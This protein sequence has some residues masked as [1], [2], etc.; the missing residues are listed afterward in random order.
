LGQQKAL[1]AHTITEKSLQ[2]SEIAVTLHRQ[3]EQNPDDKDN[4]H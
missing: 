1:F 2:V 4:N 3:K